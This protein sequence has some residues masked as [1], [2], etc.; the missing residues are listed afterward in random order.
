MTIDPSVRGGAPDSRLW[1]PIARID[2]SAGFDPSTL[3]RGGA[4][5]FSN[6]FPEL[7]LI[8]EASNAI[9][10]PL[11][12]ANLASFMTGAVPRVHH[13]AMSLPTLDASSDFTA[14]S[15]HPVGPN[16]AFTAFG[17]SEATG[18]S[19][20]LQGFSPTMFEPFFR[21]IFS[22]KD[23]ISQ[24]NEQ[25]AAPLLDVADAGALVDGLGP[26]DFTQTSS[27]GMQP[28][29]GNLPVDR[30]LVSD[31]MSNVYYEAPT[32]TQEPPPVPVT[33]PCSLPVL[34]QSEM[35]ALQ[36]PTNLFPMHGPRPVFSHP[37]LEGRHPPP[38]LPV[39]GSPPD[40]TMEELQH[41]CKFG[42]SN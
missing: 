1:E 31:L 42:S 5:A 9:S 29:D 30:R 7:S 25:G 34:P 13:G 14:S 28:F 8:E 2:A 37:E 17:A 16:H 15:F 20:G 18:H 19:R 23:E 24:Q 41:Y 6:V 22:E 4:D 33:I 36:P 38:A 40:P 39:D 21:D 27:N 35:P 3:D 32:L 10:Q 26:S 11:S 12:E